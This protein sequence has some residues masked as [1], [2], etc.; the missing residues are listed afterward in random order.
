M[1]QV[2]PCLYCGERRPPDDL[3]D[4][5]WGG[6]MCAPHVDCWVNHL[7]DELDAAGDDNMAPVISDH[8]IREEEERVSDG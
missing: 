8:D 6:H 7:R 1:I 2:K 3:V 5:P 4:H